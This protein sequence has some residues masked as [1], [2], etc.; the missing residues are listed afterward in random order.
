MGTSGNILVSVEVLTEFKLVACLMV[1]LV[2]AVTLVLNLEAEVV[3]V[4]EISEKAD[5]LPL[6]RDSLLLEGSL[7]LPLP[8]WLLDT[9]ITVFIAALLLLK[10]HTSITESSS[11]IAEDEAAIEAAERSSPLKGADFGRSRTGRRLRFFFMAD[12]GLGPVNKK[13]YSIF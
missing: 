9:L 3:E 7:V 2:E 8:L 4:I 13:M 12:I 11:L 1:G 10:S 5:P 6:S